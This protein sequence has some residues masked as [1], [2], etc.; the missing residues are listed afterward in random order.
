MR[1]QAFFK[2]FPTLKTSP[3]KLR[4]RMNSIPGART[5]VPGGTGIAQ[6]TEHT[7][8]VKRRSGL[9]LRLVVERYVAIG[10]TRRRVREKQ[11]RLMFAA[12]R[13]ISSA[14][15][16]NLSGDAASSLSS[17]VCGLSI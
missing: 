4:S 15:R 6:D 14:K 12:R 8:P 2:P 10:W 16:N 5:R 11:R 1:T 3:V 9:S 7:D 17:E 13:L